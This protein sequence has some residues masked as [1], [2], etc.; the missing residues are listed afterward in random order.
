MRKRR[1][2]LPTKTNEK[3][4]LEGACG[5]KNR[6]YDIVCLTAPRLKFP[7]QKKATKLLE[8]EGN[9]FVVAPLRGNLTR[10][11]RLGTDDLPVKRHEL[12]QNRM[13]MLLLLLMM[14]HDMIVIHHQIGPHSWR[15]WRIEMT[16]MRGI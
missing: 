15:T 1:K 7:I 3:N 13:L 9:V 12:I 10:T 2:Q 11:I 14:I 16:L 6:A 5:D 8:R 4:C